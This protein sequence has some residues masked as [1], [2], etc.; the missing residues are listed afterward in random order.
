LRCTQLSDTKSAHS[1]S[2]QLKI[3]IFK[4]LQYTLKHLAILDADTLLVVRL[5]LFNKVSVK[6]LFSLLKDIKNMLEP[7]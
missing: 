6:G 1:C 3:F 7:Y 4:F 2:D 5:S